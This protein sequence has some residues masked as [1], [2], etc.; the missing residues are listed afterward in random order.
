MQQA[1]IH[2][3]LGLHVPIVGKIITLLINA[4]ERM[5]FLRIML[6]KEERELKA[7]LAEEIQE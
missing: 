4:I 2:R 1:T 6:P 7:I 5:V 3:I